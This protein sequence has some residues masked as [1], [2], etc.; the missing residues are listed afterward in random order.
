MTTPT[1]V[2][3]LRPGD[4]ACLTFSGGE[5][6]LDIVAAFVRDGL[7]LGHKAVCFTGSVGSERLAD[8]LTERDRPGRAEPAR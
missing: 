8:E 3:A 2:E 6:R 1:P 4:H 7:D 5:E